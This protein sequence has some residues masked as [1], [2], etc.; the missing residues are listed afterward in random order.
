[1][2]AR[3]SPDVRIWFGEL[4]PIYSLLTVSTRVVQFGTISA[5]ILPDSVC[6]FMAV[7][8][9]IPVIIG[10]V[11][12]RFTGGNIP[13]STKCNHNRAIEFAIESVDSPCSHVSYGCDTYEEFREGRCFGGEVGVMGLFANNQPAEKEHF[14]VTK[15]SDGFCGTIMLNSFDRLSRKRLSSELSIIPSCAHLNHQFCFLHNFQLMQWRFRCNYRT[16]LPRLRAAF[17]SHW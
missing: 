17:S 16:R 12:V 13:E 9:Y 3:L 11:N 14:L 15:G 4:S 7:I 10:L 1:M 2:E 5:C 6:K 8:W